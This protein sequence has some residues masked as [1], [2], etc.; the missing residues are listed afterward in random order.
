MSNKGTILVGQKEICSDIR[1]FE[2]LL[3]H[4]KK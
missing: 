1:T 2:N 3:E 4:S